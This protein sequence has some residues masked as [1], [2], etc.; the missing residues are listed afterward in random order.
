[1]WLLMQRI[2]KLVIQSILELPIQTII[3][4]VVYHVNFL[5][6]FADYLLLRN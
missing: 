4:L 1:M 5:R 6:L 3:S 2:L